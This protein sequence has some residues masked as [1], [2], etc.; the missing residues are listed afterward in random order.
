ML[1]PRGALL[2]LEPLTG[3]LSTPRRPTVCVV[4]PQP[5]SASSPQISANLATAA[6]GS[7]LHM[8]MIATRTFLTH[9]SL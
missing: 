9:G 6:L 5:D 1:A 7:R 8:L 4:S 2:V 3:E